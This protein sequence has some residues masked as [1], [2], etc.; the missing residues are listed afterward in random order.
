MPRR[1]PNTL[2]VATPVEADPL[3]ENFDRL[4]ESIASIETN[5]IPRGGLTWDSF[6][7]GVNGLNAA[8]TGVVLAAVRTSDASITGANVETHLVTLTPQVLTDG[9]NEFQVSFN[10]PGLLPFYEL[11]TRDFVRYW[12]TA[13]ISIY[14]TEEPPP[15]LNLATHV[16][17]VP[18]FNT[19]TI[20]SWNSYWPTPSSNFASP[21]FACSVFSDFT[22]ETTRTATNTGRGGGMWRSVSIEGIYPITTNDLERLDIRMVCYTPTGEEPVDY[23]AIDLSAAS[24]QAMLIKKSAIY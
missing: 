16:Y 12:F 13:Q 14:W 10:N 8:P 4:A 2:S 20:E 15:L 23:L 17:V 11:E 7:H 18:Q 3:N 1:T 22:W 9:T 21:A 24:M 19:T 6:R 5:Q